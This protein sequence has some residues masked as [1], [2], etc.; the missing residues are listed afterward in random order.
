MTAKM[1]PELLT[2]IYN[3]ISSPDME[4]YRQVKQKIDHI[5]KPLDGLGRFENLIA[6]IGAIQKKK[7]ISIQKKAVIVMCA[8]NGIV[9]EGVSQSGK[10]V[11]LQVAKAMGKNQSSVGKMAAIAKVD[12]IPVDIGISTTE[13]IPG[14]LARK[15]AMGTRNFAKEPAMT[16]EETLQAIKT[17]MELVHKCKQ[18]GYEL[19]GTGEMGIGNTTTSTAVTAAL[20]HLDPIQI[21]GRGAGLGDH[22]LNRKR[23]V[24][25]KAMTDYDLEN[26]DPLSVL[27]I[28]GGLD[29]AGLTGAFLGA[30][31]YQIPI[32]IDGVISAT[33]AL[34][35]QKLC[36]GVREYMIPSHQSREASFLEIMK[37]LNMRPVLDADMALGEG[38]GTVM[39]MSLLDIAL[40]VCQS[41]STFENWDM[42]QYE[43]YT[44]PPDTTAECGLGGRI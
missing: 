41:D 33:A 9:E 12:I 2:Q 30:A 14:V 17:G 8:D 40:N 21:T 35:A 4:I 7:D 44:T 13:R 28:V 15:V 10:E 16:I 34:V 1:R 18:D 19:L 36:K 27:Q 29:L 26:V 6:R 25:Q 11:T 20:L 3:Q 38:T 5:A 42:E 23:M 39:M 37:Y 32:M 22:A 24:I 43:R 31:L